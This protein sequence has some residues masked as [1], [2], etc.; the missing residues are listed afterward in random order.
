[1]PLH[2]KPVVGSISSSPYRVG[3]LNDSAL[4]QW[5]GVVGS[6]PHGSLFHGR[7]WRQTLESSFGH[8]TG[9]VVGIWD[10]ASGE[11]VG[12]MAVYDVRSKLLGNRLVSVPYASCV[13]PMTESPEQLGMALRFL[14]RECGGGEWDSIEVRMREAPRVQLPDGVVCLQS[15]KHHYLDLRVGLDAVFRG[16][17]RTA[18]RQPIKKAEK[19]GIV[20]RVGDSKADLDAF[21]RQYWATRKHLGLPA[22]PRRF[23]DS[24]W[25]CV[26]PERRFLFLAEQ[27]NAVLGS[28]LA[29]RLN[30]TMLIEWMGDDREQ[31]NWGTIQSL[32]WSA[33][34]HA[35]RLGCS[36]FSFGQTHS[37]NSNL[38]EF[39]RRWGALE[40]EAAYLLWTRE[41]GPLDVEINPRNSRFRQLAQSVLKRSPRWVYQRL[42]ELCCR[43]M[44]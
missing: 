16:F 14:V 43:H 36:H 3:W 44:G 8:M 22:M 18:V 6:H 24:L 33:V 9:R 19:A 13:D 20:S 31:R 30:Q 1:M 23:F 35:A 15:A 11:I 40:E 29:L 10:E 7:E 21:Y 32:Y 12:G 4:A 39:K 2:S 5:E 26:A 25:R 38:L 17:S 34:Q 37:A 41:S 28:V 42:S 27:G